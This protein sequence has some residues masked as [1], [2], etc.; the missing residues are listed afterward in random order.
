M[1][2]SDKPISAQSGIGVR[3]DTA[4]AEP[5]PTRLTQTALPA[6]RIAINPL[7]AFRLRR[8]PPPAG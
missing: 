7:A 4:W 3:F 6:R 5:G 1:E 8:R 2:R